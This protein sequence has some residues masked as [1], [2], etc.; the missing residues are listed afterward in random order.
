MN[1]AASI[2][3]ARGVERDGA[4]SLLFLQNLRGR[5]ASYLPHVAF[6]PAAPFSTLVS[7]PLIF[8]P[9]Y[10]LAYRIGD[11]LTGTEPVLLEA[12]IQADIEE[13]VMVRQGEFGGWLAGML[14]W[15][16]TIGMP[17]ATGLTLL[18]I[19]AAVSGYL[20]VNTIWKMRI[21]QRWR[22]RRSAQEQTRAR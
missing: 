2:F 17:L 18:A 4:A 5:N 11:L 10:Y 8:P 15:L 14:E 6:P 16:Q 20:V 7:N 1:R 22:R 19:A 12:V 3:H 13:A 9:L 21:R